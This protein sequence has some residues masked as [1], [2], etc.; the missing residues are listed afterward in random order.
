MENKY[1]TSDQIFMPLLKYYDI[2]LEGKGYIME[3]FITE[4]M[5][6][7]Y[8]EHLYEEEKPESTV[9]KYMRDLRKLAGYMAGREVTKKLVAGYKKYLKEKKGYKLTS[10]NSFLVAANRLFE[11]L[12]WYDMRVRTYRIQKEVFVPESRNLSKAE[13]KRLVKAALNKGNKRL[14]M[15]IQTV[16][17]TGMRI[18]ELACVTFES[19]TEGVVEIYC[20]GKQ[21][22]ILLPGKLRKKLQRYIKE[23]RIVS[24]VV[25]CTS[26]GK[27]VDRSNIWK[28]MKLISEDA[29]IYRGKV[30]PHN[31]R[32]LFAKEFYAAGKD[33][34]KLADVLGH[35]NIETTRGYIK[36]TSIE[37][38][39][40]LDRMGLVLESA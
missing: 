35:S 7:K 3:R 40:L 34:A 4:E 32:H 18:S 33:I 15:I 27:A 21:R 31:L 28:E 39:K 9:K 20:K 1:Y 16:C 22:I 24:G 8:Q 26:G 38:Q 19:V 17:A 5:L 25:F 29:G 30:Y 36:S 23:N 11:Y 12:G 37:H 13:Y 10:I 14:A 2:N 6:S